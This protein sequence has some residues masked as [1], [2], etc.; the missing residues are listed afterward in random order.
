MPAGYFRVGQ[1]VR[2][3]SSGVVPEG[4]IG[5]IQQAYRSADNCYEVWFTGDSHG[6]VMPARDLERA[7][8]APSTDQRRPS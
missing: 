6:R 5:I 4:T 1:R 8:H 3:R 2:T 7:N